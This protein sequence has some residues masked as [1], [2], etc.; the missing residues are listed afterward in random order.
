M[1]AF[2]TFHLLM[3][4][5][6]ALLNVHCGTISE[7]GSVAYYFNILKKV[8][9]ASKKPNFHTLLTAL[10]QILKGLIFNA[11]HEECGQPSLS[12]F[13]KANLKPEDIIL[14][15]QCIIKKYTT[16]TSKVWYSQECKEAQ[17]NIQQLWLGGCRNQA[18]LALLV[19]RNQVKWHFSRYY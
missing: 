8:C 7:H 19:S 10:T 9:L 17:E 14:I 5:I 13:V 18:I 2:G 12:D 4:L 6:W 1:L 15:A 16:L 3:N 11:W